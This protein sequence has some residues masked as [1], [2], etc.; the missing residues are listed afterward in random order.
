MS[1]VRV[2]SAG[3]ED[4]QERLQSPAPDL[5]E[6]GSG[7]DLDAKFNLAQFSP[8]AARRLSTGCAT[9]DVSLQG[10]QNMNATDQSSF[11][12]CQDA[13]RGSQAWDLYMVGLVRPVALL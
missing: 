4:R 12:Q 9:A 13:Y 5:A 10:C 11:Q 6:D 8:P 2:L 7:E 1:K 3:A